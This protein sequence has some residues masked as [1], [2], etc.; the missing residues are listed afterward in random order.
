M[1]Y[2]YKM[3]EILKITKEERNLGSK[4]PEL[5][6]GYQ[7]I[8]EAGYGIKVG[9]YGLN[10]LKLNVINGY[11]INNTFSGGIG[12]GVRYYSE[13]GQSATVIPLFADFRANLS[14]NSIA[15][16]VAVD[17]GYSFDASD[18][19]TGLGA[20]VNPSVGVGFHLKN[21]SILNV[22]LGYELQRINF[23]YMD[24]NGYERKDGKN[25]NAISLNVGISF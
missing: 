23:S 15:P 20:L 10:V 17:L 24:W 18:K 3:D 25:T 8:V 7:G 12:T 14:Q 13:D 9:L 1:N 19:F 2:V 6:K 4:R 16:Y 5:G 11:R 21:K 22:G